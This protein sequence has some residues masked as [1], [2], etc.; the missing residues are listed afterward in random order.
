MH[1]ARGPHFG[2]PGSRHSSVSGVSILPDLAVGLE[3]GHHVAHGAQQRLVQII[4]SPATRES[5]LG[6]RC[7]SVCPCICVA[8]RSVS[9]THDLV[10]CQQLEVSIR[11]T[12]T[13]THRY[14]NVYTARWEYLRQ[15]TGRHTKKRRRGSL[16]MHSG[17]AGRKE[18]RFARVTKA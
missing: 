3:G 18:T 8:P 16:L 4:V 11:N 7:S 9:G 2:G 14:K 15:C 10:C 12:T 1:V 13:L 17:H 5:V 6:M